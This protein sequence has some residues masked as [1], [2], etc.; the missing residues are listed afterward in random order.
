MVKLELIKMSNLL[1][2]TF[3]SVVSAVISCGTS[4]IC[5]VSV[6]LQT[7]LKVFSS[8]YHSEQKE[9]KDVLRVGV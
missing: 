4:Q 1:R 7:N 2:V 5:P 9:V 6:A 3:Y 8:D